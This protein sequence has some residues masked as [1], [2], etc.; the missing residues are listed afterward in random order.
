MTSRKWKNYM[1]KLRQIPFML[2]VH[3]LVT[4]SPLREG[5]SRRSWTP[6]RSQTCTVPALSS[7]WGL[8]P[9]PWQGHERLPREPLS[10]NHGTCYDTSEDPPRVCVGEIS[11]ITILHNTLPHC[12]ALR[13]TVVLW[14]TIQLLWQQYVNVQLLLIVLLCDHCPFTT[15]RAYTKPSC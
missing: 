14:N 7:Q 15:G 5:W 1:R 3:Y 9:T 13:K 4:T 8:G 2:H 11:Y 6:H 12:T 10:E